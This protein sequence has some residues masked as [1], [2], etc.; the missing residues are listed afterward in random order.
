MF[1]TG[2]DLKKA[3]GALSKLGISKEE[4]VL[5]IAPG[6]AF[7]PAKRWPAER[8]AKVA[9]KA[10]EEWG[11][12]VLIFG[13]AGDRDSCLEVE[14]QMEYN[15]FNLCGRTELGEAMALIG[16][17]SM[18]L[19]NDSGLMHVAS[20]LDIPT[21]AIFGSTDHVATGPISNKARVVRSQ[22]ECPPCLKPECPGDFRCMLRIF[23]GEVFAELKQLMHADATNGDKK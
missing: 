23:P 15:P 10:V 8:F 14:S 12:R 1:L 19:T 18:F 7:G 11:V 20:A 5:G 16:S 6:A 22:V 17:C 13:S 4:M 9:D 3:E 21:V 2:R